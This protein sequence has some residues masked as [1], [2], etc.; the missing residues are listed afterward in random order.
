MNTLDTGPENEKML[1]DVNVFC[2]IRN[3]IKML[4]P[5]YCSMSDFYPVLFN[6]ERY[7]IRAKEYI[8]KFIILISVW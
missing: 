3:C 1:K 6:Y 2:F 7:L 8:A 5:G 4:Q